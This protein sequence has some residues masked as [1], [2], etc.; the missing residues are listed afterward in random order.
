MADAP[1][2]PSP[3]AI[4]TAARIRHKIKYTPPD[5]LPDVETAMRAISN[6]EQI[7]ALALDA[8]AAQARTAAIEAA[9]KLGTDA[10]QVASIG[11]RYAVNQLLEQLRAL[12]RPTGE[13][14]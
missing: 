7:I 3:E 14:K 4:H 11:E 5:D 12:A 1:V 8:C 6:V 13:S 10:L 9:V 2:E